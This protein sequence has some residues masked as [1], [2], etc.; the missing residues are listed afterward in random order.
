MNG[1]YPKGWVFF[2]FSKEIIRNAFR[3]NRIII[4]AKNVVISGVLI[5]E[6]TNYE[7]VEWIGFL[8]ADNF[9]TF[10]FLLRQAKKRAIQNKNNELQIIL[11]DVSQLQHFCAKS[12]FES[13]ERENDVFL[14][15]FADDLTS[16]DSR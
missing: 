11:P 12:G 5:L 16:H 15:E 7:N 1:F 4:S 14:Y 3:Q 2:P 13:W 6:P 8:E 10:S 9:T